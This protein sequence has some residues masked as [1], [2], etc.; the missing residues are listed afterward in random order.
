MSR[1]LS[2]L[3]DNFTAIK[4][5]HLALPRGPSR[6]DYLTPGF[7]IHVGDIPP[8]TISVQYRFEKL[9]APS[10]SI[11]NGVGRLNHCLYDEAILAP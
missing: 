8:S 5:D 4:T 7:I 1:Q 6:D 2:E 10:E 9:K 11:R 3:E